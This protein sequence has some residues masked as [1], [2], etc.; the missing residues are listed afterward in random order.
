MA[1]FQLAKD[2]SIRARLCLGF[3][4]LVVLAL[5]QGLLGLYYM[6]QINERVRDMYTQ[7]LV[8]LEALDDAK[9]GTYR[10]RGDALEHILAGSEASQARL[11][12]EI[13]DQQRRIGERVRQYRS[14]RLSDEENRLISAFD[15]HFATYIERVKKQILPLSASGRK[16]EAV[17]LVAGSA[18]QDF[19]KAR[20]AMNE[21]MDYNTRRAQTRYESA[22]S[23][24]ETAA[25][26]VLII[27]CTISVLGGLISFFLTRAITEP[28]SRVVG[29]FDE[30]ARGNLKNRIEVRR[31]DEIGKVL[32][33]LDETQSNLAASIAERE[34]AEKE[35]RH[36]LDFTSAITSSPGEGVCALDREGRL[37]FMNRA[38]EQMLGWSQGEILGQKLCEVIHPRQYDRAYASIAESPM[39]TKIRLGIAYR[40][41]DEVF[42]RRDGRT[43]PVAYTLSA[44]SEDKHPAGRVLVFRD[45]TERKAF[46]AQLEYQAFHDPLTNLPNRSLFMDRLEHAL[47]SLG[48]G[49]RCIAVLFLDLDRFKLI[50]DSLGHEV[51]DQ[52]LRA[53]AERLRNRL[54]AGDTAARLGG[55]EFTVLLSDITDTSGAVRVAERITEDMQAPFILEGRE[56]FVSTSIGI[57]VAASSSD[58]S[59]DLLKDADIAMYRAKAKGWA[60]YEVFDK[61]MNAYALQRLDLEADLHRAMER[62]ELRVYYQ[63]KLDLVSGRIEGMEALV[64]WQHPQRNL[65][66]PA[67]FIPMAEETGLI[68]PI[69]LWMVQQVC[70][71]GRLWQEQYP[72]EPPL[73]MGVNLSVRQFQHAQLVTE[74]SKILK[75]SGLDAHRLQFEVTES[76]VMENAESTIKRMQGLK[77]L[78]VQLAIDDFGT[79][80]SS[81]SYLKRF[82][83]DTLKID[84]SFIN[85][86]G[87][88]LEDTA[89]VQAVITLAK[90]LQVQVTAEGVETAE[91]A[92]HLMSLGC[93]L[94]QGYYFSE[95]L[96]V[97]LASELL[98]TRVGATG[99]RT[100]QVL[101]GQPA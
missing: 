38:A 64:R 72:S 63:P 77:A 46:E 58:S 96:S 32:L 4:T 39:P 12:A 93:D 23:N 62:G 35:L 48:R 7:E 99:T 59:V 89:I 18:V 53:V 13:D 70:R 15:T 54:R 21:L 87:Q 81:L 44:S 26:T 10:I 61:S 57:S 51:G 52:L 69:G 37:T 41:D 82:P 5:L 17:A 9:S 20:D 2:A 65:I 24:Y 98:A 79:G 73:V 66:H 1:R 75:E 67:E 6:R 49:H 3:G 8:V 42:T 45:I 33:S 74:V 28:L 100:L 76:V 43:F 101:E 83:I 86:L 95:P 68:L 19:R 92:R 91:Q 56:V 88:D 94:A 11:E 25:W 90:T 27:I 60:G 36:Q 80:Y 30:I 71:Q 85:G 78:G 84:R 29:Y 55:D 40:A 47:K 14:T 97:E 50:N 16:E 31:R 22:V 34:R